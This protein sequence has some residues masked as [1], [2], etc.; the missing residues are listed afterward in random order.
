MKYDTSNKLEANQA[1]EKLNYLISKSKIVELKT[2]RA[3]RSI[4]QNSYLHVVITLWAIHVG[5]T[6]N[7]AKTDLKRGCHFMSYEKNGKKYL[8]ETKK[9]N[10]KQ[11]TEFIDWIRT[12]ASQNG[13]YIPTAQEYLENKYRIDNEI[14]LNKEF[15]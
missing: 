10:S 12:M 6:I 2:V 15:L 9:Q 3:K 11:L 13:L 5:L 8:I 4:S 7:E 1:K 14:E